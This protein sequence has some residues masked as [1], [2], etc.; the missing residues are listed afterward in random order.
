MKGV[1]FLDEAITFSSQRLASA[2]K[3]MVSHVVLLTLAL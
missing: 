2:K 3:E 1:Y